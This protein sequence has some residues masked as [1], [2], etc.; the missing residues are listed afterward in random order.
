[1]SYSKASRVDFVGIV[2]IMFAMVL[3]GSGIYFLDKS[4][5][6]ENK[7]VAMVEE[8]KVAGVQETNTEQ[9]V[10]EIIKNNIAKKEVQMENSNEVVNNVKEDETKSNTTENSVDNSET[11]KQEILASYKLEDLQKDQILINA[12]VLSINGSSVTYE[13]TQKM[14]EYNNEERPWFN[15]TGS[16][17]TL[18]GIIGDSKY[19]EQAINQTYE[20]LLVVPKQSSFNIS[21]AVSI[22]KLN[23]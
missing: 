9:W 11:L 7:V 13:F 21:D 20:L 5:V 16:K 17:F 1:M 4:F 3:V 8:S 6:T 14:L 23:K 2:I 19:D 22:K 18:A 12:K 10:Q 15:T